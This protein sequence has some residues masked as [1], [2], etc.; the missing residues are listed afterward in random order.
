MP[1]DLDA[2]FR[3]FIRPFGAAGNP[4]NITGG[5]P[6]ITYVNTVKLPRRGLAVSFVCTLKLV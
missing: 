3:K 5:E 4:V 2:T 1:A 6:P